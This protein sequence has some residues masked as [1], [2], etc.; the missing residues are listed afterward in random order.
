MR[1]FRLVTAGLVLAVV[2]FIGLTRGLLV[3]PNLS[4]WLLL[5]M[6]APFVL[7]VRYPSWFASP[8]AGLG[9][10]AVV[11]ASATALMVLD[12]AAHDFVAIVF[13]IVAARVAAEAPLV[14]GLAVAAL[15]MA[16]PLVLAVAGVGVSSPNLIVGTAFAWF[17]GYEVRTQQHLLHALVD[18][19]IKLAD[20][21]AAAERQHI[22]RE[23]HDLVAHTLSVTMLHLTGARLALQDADVT[24][25]TAALT[26]AERAGRE[27]V[28]EMRQAVGLL[29]AAA[30]TGR[31]LPSATDIPE[32]ITSYQNAGLR[33][34]FDIQGDLHA[35]SDDA[36]LA[37][38]RITQE[39]LSNAAK[40]APSAQTLV[41]V[42]VRAKDVALTVR[43]DVY[44]PSG[45][46]RGGRG[47]PGMAERAA[48]LGGSFSAGP[49]GDAWEVRAV[50]PCSTA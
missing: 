10:V 44:A 41:V 22:A 15:V 46:P 21:A 17:A 32:L 39:S 4:L 6:A 31:P 20:Q 3:P 16:L 23:V 37:L 48:Q 49:V 2:A 13:V 40:H 26:E 28:R 14:L 8:A 33:V 50:L 47:L 7:D 18:A 30:S 29:G 43:N 25:A 35:I 9:A 12:P 5:L 1:R 34:A 38:Y 45:V 42:E 11:L 19:Q 36:G 24:E 27:A